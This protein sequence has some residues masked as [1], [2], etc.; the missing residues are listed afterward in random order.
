M[1]YNGVGNLHFN[2]FPGRDSLR[3][4]SLLNEVHLNLNFVLN[5]RKVV[6]IK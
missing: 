3:L 6:K 2:L 1:K 4:G 5:Q